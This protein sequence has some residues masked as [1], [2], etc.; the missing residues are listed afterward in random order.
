M[1]VGAAHPCIE[2]WL[3]ADGKAIKRA[4]ILG[5][6]PNLPESPEELPAPQHDRANNPKTHLASIAGTNKSELSSSAKD[7]IAA[8]IK[9]TALICAACPLG[10][11]A[12]AVEVEQRIKPIFGTSVQE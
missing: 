3:L 4:L 11:G 5:T 6:A 10:F 9:D 2:A 8:E 12:F 7:R 1:A